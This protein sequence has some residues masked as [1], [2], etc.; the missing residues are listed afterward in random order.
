MPKKS[1][2]IGFCIYCDSTESLTNEHVV[3]K[4]L[5]GD[6]TLLRASCDKCSKITSKLEGDALSISRNGVPGI[7]YTLRVM[8]GM[9]SRRGSTRNVRLRQSIR[10]TSTGEEIEEMVDPDNYIHTLMLPIFPEPG[11]ITGSP[12]PG[13]L[14]LDE[15]MTYVSNTN[16]AKKGFQYGCRFSSR[17]GDFPRLLAKI[18]YCHVIFELGFESVKDS[19][20]KEIILQNSPKQSTW[21][22]CDQVRNT[23][24]LNNGVWAIEL[25]SYKG[26][27]GVKIK[28]LPEFPDQTPEYIV[29]V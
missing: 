24:G 17:A 12:N 2:D 10:N 16:K 11:C 8:S 18:A 4:A 14:P 20:V 7:L 15:W 22:G 19:P 27:R 9:P 21:I 23:I 28:F 29:I 13:G 25:G 3:P 1:R 6:R 5:G 26:S